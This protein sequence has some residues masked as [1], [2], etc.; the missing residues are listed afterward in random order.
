[1][2]SGLMP[3]KNKILVVDDDAEFRAALS[4]QLS[5]HVEFEVVAAGNGSQGLQAAEEGR[6]DLVIMDVGLPD[7]N[8]REVVRILRRN[9]FK[10]PIIML[11]GH[12]ADSDIILGLESGANDYVSKPCR[13]GVLL[14]RAT[15]LSSTK[16]VRMPRLRSARTLFCQPRSGS[17]IARAAKSA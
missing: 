8:G 16:G 11:T 4:E 9:G 12:N 1:M 5:L 3:N 6:I 14:A 10:A 13:F 7:I 2:G 15:S 17:S